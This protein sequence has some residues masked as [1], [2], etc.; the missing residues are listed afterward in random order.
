M[1]KIAVLI[2]GILVIVMGTSSLV[3]GIKLERLR[4]VKIQF[5]A[6]GPGNYSLGIG[7]VLIILGVI[8]MMFEY[9]KGLV[10]EKLVDKRLRR[11]M[12]S[13]IVILAVYCFLMNIIGYLLASI[14]FFISVFRVVGF[15]SWLYI[16]G[17]SVGIS[18]SY[19]IIFVRLLGMVFPQ[20][21]VIP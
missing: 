7:I 9:R 17:L 2:E 3:Y 14:I 11:K 6:L 13:L 20:G 15:R 10:E 4:G 18:V 5:D 21:I 19:Y 8:Y 1:N 16:L 12:I